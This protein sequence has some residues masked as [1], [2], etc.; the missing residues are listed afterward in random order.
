MLFISAFFISLL[1]L[2]L[3]KTRLGIAIRALSMDPVA[4][5]LMGINISLVI[6]MCFFMSGILAAISGVFLG[7]NY[8]LQ[9][10]LA[11]M[12][13]K[14]FTAAILGGLGNIT[15]ALYGGIILGVAEVFLIYSVGSGY[16]PV[17]I[18]FLTIA[19]LIWR[20]QGISGKFV[21]VKV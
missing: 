1:M 19:F 5:R 20:P 8:V 16:A 11:N 13:M 15:G 12:V 4:A 10:Q 18:F 7:I 3:Y 6:G 17:V 9:P 14:G 2:V 21:N